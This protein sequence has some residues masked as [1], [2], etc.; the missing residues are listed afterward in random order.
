MYFLFAGL[1]L[2]IVG[3]APTVKDKILFKF[4][5]LG[6]ITSIGLCL[7]DLFTPGLLV[8]LSLMSIVA[9]V[10]KYRKKNVYI[11]Y[12]ELCCFILIFKYLMI[13]LW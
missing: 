12:I 7:F 10:M 3:L 9:I 11:T 13:R 5:M 4:H 2:S 1:F 6:A 8:P